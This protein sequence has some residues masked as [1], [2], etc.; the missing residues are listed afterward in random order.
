MAS[1]PASKTVN[2]HPTNYLP[3]TL[4]ATTFDVIVIGSGPCGR[5]VGSKTAAGGLNT[6]IIEDELWGGDCP[7]WACMPSKALLRPGEALAAARQ[8]GGAKQLIATDKKVDLPG[9]LARRDKI[10]QNYSDQ[11]F[12]NLSLKQD[13][14][15]VRGRGT[16]QSEKTVLV[17]HASGDKTLTAR[18]AVVIATGSEPVI[19]HDI[20]GIHDI[21]VWTP[22]EATS[23]KEIPE[24]LIV[25]GG[26]VVGSEMATAYATYG[27]KVTVITPTSEI[28][29]RYEPEAG[30]RVREALAAQN[31]D[32]HLSS[33]VVEAWKEPSTGLVSVKLSS[34]T[35]VTGS[36]VLL[37]A[38][39]RP[40]TKNIGLESIGLAASLDVDPTTLVNGVNGHWLYAVGDANWKSPTTHMG[41]YQARIAAGAIIARAAPSA[42]AQTLNSEPWGPHAATADDLAVSQ[43]VVTD[44][45]VG[46]VGLTLAAALKKG[47]KAQAVDV[48]FNFPGAW[49]FAEFDYDGWARW[50][51]DTDKNVLVGAT[52]V[53]RETGDL[54]HASTVAL[55][56]QVPLDRLVHAVPSFPTRSEVYGLLLEKW[57][58]TRDSPGDRRN[59]WK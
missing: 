16:L 49:V 46:S 21:D 37:A 52:I 55:V 45:N 40:R 57:L 9:V 28:L 38:G 44:P 1:A 25:I 5:Q 50:V 15:V 10:V 32:F 53:G 18:H 31:V 3:S 35:V 2:L 54:L 8:V 43:V 29:D 6:V 13:C 11:F 27:S 24:H 17:K 42:S 41:E 4:E 33:R 7:F 47:I 30:R 26:G 59:A 22:R 23:V 12:V 48:E 51:V 19:P 36:A 14:T 34:G 56:G 58:A 20:K 39:R